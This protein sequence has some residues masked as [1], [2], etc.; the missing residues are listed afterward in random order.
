MSKN[1]LRRSFACAF[2]GL[3]YGALRE[4]NFKIHLAAAAVAVTAGFCLNI[5]RIEWAIIML[6]IFMVLAAEMIN[7]AIENTVDMYSGDY[8]YQAKIAKDAAA[9]GVLLTA[10]NAVVVAILI[11]GPYLKRIVAGGMF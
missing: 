5:T 9:G 1:P 2:N 8:C 11:F 7:T 10:L 6:T 3:A 4:R